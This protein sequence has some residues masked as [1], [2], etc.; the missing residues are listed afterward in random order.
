MN[1]RMAEWTRWIDGI[2]ERET[3]RHRCQIISNE[4]NPSCFDNNELFSTNSLRTHLFVPLRR[5]P[6]EHPPIPLHHPT[7][8]NTAP[9]DSDLSCRRQIF[10]RKPEPRIT[11]RQLSI[12][13]RQPSLILV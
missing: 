11:E 8:I 1:E 7:C 2:S 10:F 6:L 3:C 9:L 12:N 4:S 13:R 5:F